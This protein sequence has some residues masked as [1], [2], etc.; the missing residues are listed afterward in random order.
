[1]GEEQE[2]MKSQSEAIS[3]KVLVTSQGLCILFGLEL[4]GSQFLSRRGT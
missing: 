3:G 1:M 4:E 2:T